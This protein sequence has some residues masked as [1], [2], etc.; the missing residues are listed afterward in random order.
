[1]PTLTWMN[2]KSLNLNEKQ[3]QKITYY[4]ILFLGHPEKYKSIGTE[5]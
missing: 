2:I 4:M 5:I 1:M 3:S